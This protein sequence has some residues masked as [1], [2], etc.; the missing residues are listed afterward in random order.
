MQTALNG[1]TKDSGCG[2]AAIYPCGVRIVADRLIRL[3]GFAENTF[4]GEKKMMREEQHGAS[5]TKEQTRRVFVD[6]WANETLLQRRRV[7]LEIPADC[8]DSELESV[9]G[10]TLDDMANAQQVESWYET[11]EADD[12]DVLDGISVEVGVPEHI[13]SDLVL[14]RCDDELVFRGPE[15]GDE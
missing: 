9:G 3:Q 12:F 6:L 7:V 2:A 10:I 8:S 15:E 5:V 14:V 4:Y 1:A 13:E 11:E